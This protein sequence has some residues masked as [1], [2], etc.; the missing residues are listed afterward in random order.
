LLDGK[1]SKLTLEQLPVDPTNYP[2][3]RDHMVEV[4]LFDYSH[5]HSA[6]SLTDKKFR[7]KKPIVREVIKVRLDKDNRFT[8]VKNIINSQAPVAIFPNYNDMFFGKV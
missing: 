5:E 1:I 7:R 2:V 4:A 3:L 6:S 8:E